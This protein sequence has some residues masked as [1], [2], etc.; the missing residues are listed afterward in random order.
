MWSATTTRNQW[1]QRNDCTASLQGNTHHGWT[2]CRQQQANSKLQTEASIP[3]LALISTSAPGCTL[4]Q[5]RCCLLTAP[6]ASHPPGEHQCHGAQTPQLKGTPGQVQLLLVLLLL[7]LLVASPAPGEDP[8]APAA[9]ASVQ[10]HTHPCYCCCP[11]QMQHC[12]GQQVGAV[13]CCSLDTCC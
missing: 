12:P 11:P 1:L 9:A 13:A 10:P 4:V 8:P 5:Q 2:S 6:P 3:I 7:L